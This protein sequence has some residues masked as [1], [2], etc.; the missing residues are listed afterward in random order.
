M[1][2]RY[3]VGGTGTWDNT[4]TTNWSATSGGASGASAPTSVD[5]VF[6]D[7]NSNV[8][9]GTFTVTTGG[10]TPACNNFL[11]SGLDGA[12]TLTLTVSVALN[13]YGDFTISG[14]FGNLVTLQSSLAGTRANL[15][16]TFGSVNVSYCSIKDL[17]AYGGSEWISLTTNGNVNAGNNK[18][19]EF[20]DTGKKRI[21]NEAPTFYDQFGDPLAGGTL[22]AYLSGTSEETFIYSNSDGDIAGTSI[23]LNSNG[24]FAT[25][26]IWVDPLK[27]YKFLLR[28][29]EGSQLWTIDN[30]TSCSGCPITIATENYFSSVLDSLN[31]STAIEITDNFTANIITA[32][33]VGWRTVRGNTAKDRNKWY[34]EVRNDV[35]AD[36]GTIG[37]LV[38]GIGT[39]GASLTSDFIGNQPGSGFFTN[40][41][42]TANN[43]VN[44][45]V[46]FDNGSPT[47]V[48]VP[49]AAAGS[50]IMVAVD[51]TTGKVW[52][53]VDGTWSGDPVVGTGEAATLTASAGYGF[54]PYFSLYNADNTQTFTVNFGAEP[55]EYSIPGGFL[56]WDALLG[57]A[58]SV[59]SD[60]LSA[61]QLA[62][63]PGTDNLQVYKTYFASTQAYVGFGT[64]ANFS[65][66]KYFEV[67]NT[68]AG[69]YNG[70]TYENWQ[71]AV[72]V[73]AMLSNPTLYDGAYVMGQGADQ[74]AYSNALIS[75][76]DG[77]TIVTGANFGSLYIPAAAAPQIPQGGFLGVAVDFDAGKIWFNRN[78]SWALSGD[79]VAGTNPI[80]TFTPNLTMFPGYSL[81]WSGSSLFNTTITFNF[82]STDFVDLPVGFV[83]WDDAGTD[84]VYGLY[85][86]ITPQ[87]FGNDGLPLA[88][89][90]IDVYL[91]GTATPGV[92]YSDKDG[93]LYGTTIPLDDRGEPAIA[94]AI[95][96]NQALEYDFVVK[97]VDGNTVYTETN[98]TTCTTC[99]S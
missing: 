76:S 22:S 24:Q 63:S 17:N 50:Y 56:R 57:S 2:D 6:F 75:L 60:Y 13:V 89:G 82:G 64:K 78:G 31:V 25:G 84:V 54:Y 67:T 62:I 38:V 36:N 73:N 10:T 96:L 85:S 14:T 9:I 98:V 65:G 30:V 46:Y 53:G 66:K 21:T 61:G 1:A 70:A 12:M 20:D 28:D 3:W 11:A 94:K 86:R 51:A 83:G 41:G 88:N 16:K 45:Q 49:V 87:F 47:T 48:S 92:A 59:D 5:N 80:T 32:G 72:G 29:A 52:F 79:P 18:G 58:S 15:I 39:F 34:F 69:T 95:W 97:D 74:I 43:P 35:N 42:F 7:A 71:W 90:S 33:A 44:R 91:A 81:V 37:Y 23:T 8:G 93:A 27:I 77:G 19:W 40:V 99:N 55:F 68:V 26:G 4:S